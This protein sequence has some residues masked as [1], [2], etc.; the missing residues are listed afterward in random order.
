MAVYYQ[1]KESGLWVW[2]V[3]IQGPVYTMAKCIDGEC[4]HVPK[5]EMGDWEEKDEGPWPCQNPNA[6]IPTQYRGI[7]DG[8]CEV[9][10]VEI[11]DSQG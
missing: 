1:N 7:L 11:Y 8:H 3:T 9:C 6:H 2:C 5:K 4:F 10:K